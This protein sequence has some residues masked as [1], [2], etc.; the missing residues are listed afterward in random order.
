MKKL[1]LSVVLA[2][3]CAIGAYGQGGFSAGPAGA[4][5][6]ND[7]G[8]VD[9]SGAVGI[10]GAVTVAGVLTATSDLVAA[11]TN[12]PV[13]S[14]GATGTVS[15]TETVQI[16]IGEKFTV[17]DQTYTFTNTPT[18]P[19]SIAITL[20]GPSDAHTNA[21]TMSNAWAA[22]SVGVST[23]I[24]NVYGPITK[25]SNVTVAKTEEDTI[26]LKFTANPGYHGTLGNAFV[27]T[28]TGV[29][30]A[31]GTNLAVTGAGT[32][33]GGVNG[34]P[35]AKGTIRVHGTSISFT[36]RDSV[37]ENAVWSTK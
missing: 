36:T 1:I 9:M 10:G 30:G 3:L 19:N 24:P 35:G 29:A 13:S 17:N 22:L 27:L 37:A 34:T 11:N 12:V 8:S 16:K 28:R 25:P 21:V 18:A 7:D 6:V 23:G 4:F 15:A 14:V 26:K 5:N 32:L 2:G 20:L 31:T 33:T